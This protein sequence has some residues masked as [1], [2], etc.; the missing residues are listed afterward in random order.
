MVICQWERIALMTV[1]LSIVST[2]AEFCVGYSSLWL[3]LHNHLFHNQWITYFNVYFVF[4][5]PIW[6]GKTYHHDQWW[7]VLQSF[8]VEYAILKKTRNSSHKVTAW[9]LWQTSD[10]SNLLWWNCGK[11]VTW[12]TSRQHCDVTNMI[13][14]WLLPRQN[15]LIQKLFSAFS[16]VLFII[17]V[18]Y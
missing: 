18:S 2:L 15:Y 9:N 14:A 3:Q 12:Q 16:N 10:R 7:L 11:I 17:S 1:D 13:F 4:G 6:A 8:K 5:H